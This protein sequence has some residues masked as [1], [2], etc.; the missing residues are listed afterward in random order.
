M[1]QRN[2]LRWYGRVLRKDE[3]DWVRCM[4]CEAGV[5]PRDRSKKSWKGVVD[6]DLKCASDAADP[7]N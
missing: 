2:R 1:F 6:K 5:R 3:G 4:D 7:K